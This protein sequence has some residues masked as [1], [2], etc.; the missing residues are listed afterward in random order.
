MVTP[1]GEGSQ[2]LDNAALENCIARFQRNGDMQSLSEIVEL[3]QRR[4]LTLIRFNATT[5]Y[6]SEDELLSD[7]NFKLLRSIAKFNPSKGSAFTYIS[8]VITS[9]LRTS[10]STQRRNWARHVELDEATVS[11]L[12][13]NGETESQDAVDD[14]A[15]RIKSGVTTTLSDQAELQTMR[16]YVESFL[17]GAFEL[18]RHQCADAAMAVYG[19]THERS[20]ELYDLRV[21]ACRQVMYD[22]LPP[23]P[24]I[25]PGRLVG[26][27][28]AWMLRYAHL[29]DAAEFTKFVVLSHNLGAFIVMLIDPQSSSRRLDRNP[30]VTRQNLLW[31]LNGH[32][33]AVPLFK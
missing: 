30:T 27:R 1:N 7:I 5:S 23:R 16:W 22:T 14:L 32:P 11:R 13:T 10:V 31:I 4:A 3:S 21:L 9:T 26:T 28:S 17:N 2:H 33:D 12:H 6:R 20:R 15:D 29:L 24:A 19:L 25:A 8:A 18:R